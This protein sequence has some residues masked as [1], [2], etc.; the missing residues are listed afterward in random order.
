MLDWAKDED[1]LFSK[2]ENGEKT[3]YNPLMPGDAAGTPRP[4]NNLTEM[5]QNLVT[6]FLSDRV[7]RKSLA[8]MH[9]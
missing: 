4:R 5:Q 6:D 9:R 3:G 8:F 7:A 1:V 2:I